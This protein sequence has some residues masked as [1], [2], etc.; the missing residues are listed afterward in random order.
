MVASLHGWI[1]V[2]VGYMWLSLSCQDGAKWLYR[3]NSGM[4]IV[5]NLCIC[6]DG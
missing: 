2:M 5:Y 4:T 6:Q 1:Y 3:L